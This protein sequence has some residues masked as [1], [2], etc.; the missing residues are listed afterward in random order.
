MLENEIVIFEFMA[1]NYY[2]IFFGL[3]IEF[4]YYFF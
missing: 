4:A 3:A 1:I 2:M